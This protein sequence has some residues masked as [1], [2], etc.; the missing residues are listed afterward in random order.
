MSNLTKYPTA[1]RE[2]STVAPRPLEVLR[3]IPTPPAGFTPNYDE[4]EFAKDLGGELIDYSAPDIERP[5]YKILSSWTPDAGLRL[6]ID[7]DDNEF[8]TMAEVRDLITTLQETLATAAAE[9]ITP[10]A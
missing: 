1:L 2:H 7:H 5:G 8:F 3:S 4:N 9:S 6:Y 10:H